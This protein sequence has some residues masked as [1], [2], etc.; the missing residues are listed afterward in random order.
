MKEWTRYSDIYLFT[1]SETQS[2]QQWR[3]GHDTATS[4]FVYV[5]WNT[6]NATMKERTQYSDNSICLCTLKHNQCNNEGTDT[7]QRHLYL[8]MYAETQ[9][10]QQWRNGH[11]TAT[12]LFVYVRWNT[13][14]ATMKE[15][16]RYSD[17]SICLCTL[18][19]NQC[20]NEGTDTI[21]RHL[22][23]FMYAEMQSMQQWRNGHDTATSLFV[24]VH[25]NT[26]NATM[27][28]R[29]R[30]SDISI[31]LCKLKHNQ[32]NNEGTDTIQRYL[33]LF[34]YAETQS[35][36]QWRNGHDTATSLFVYV[37]WNTINATMKERT[38]YSDISICLC[39][40]KHNQCN[41]DGTNR[42]QWYYYFEIWITMTI[43]TTMKVNAW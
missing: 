40:L 18:K 35:M 20:N 32:C 4:L 41:N 6:I 29:T 36:Q 14:N 22:Y 33:Y 5:H 9:S 42:R 31:C 8:F 38:R 19:H 10:M 24:Y 16:I 34:M 39:T 30:Y 2:M 25:W 17:I 7:I 43:N 13:I 15:R 1:Y 3:N 28:E 27:K 37:H 11:D 23:L 26:I 21:Q 12:S